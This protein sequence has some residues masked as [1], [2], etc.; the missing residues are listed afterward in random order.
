MLT[1]VPERRSHDHVRAGTTPL[2]A[3]REVA[4]ARG[5]ACIRPMTVT[6]VPRC[7]VRREGPWRG[8]CGSARVGV[9]EKGA[10][11]LLTREFRTVTS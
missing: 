6:A 9:F 8:R 7:A 5:A 3:A 4:R 11:H 1:G 10:E 2:F